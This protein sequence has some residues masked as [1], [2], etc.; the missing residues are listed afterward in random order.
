MEYYGY[1]NEKAKEALKILS[2]DELKII[3]EKLQKGGK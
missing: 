1:S 2:D 3:E